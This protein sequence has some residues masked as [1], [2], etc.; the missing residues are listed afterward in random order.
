[1]VSDG[2]DDHAGG[3]G[4]ELGSQLDRRRRSVFVRDALGAL[5]RDQREVLVAVYFGGRSPSTVGRELA[6]S[7][8]DV[9]RLLFRGLHQLGSAINASSHVP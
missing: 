6:L 4:L 3:V 2:G 7:S 9:R 5:P 1:M 8:T